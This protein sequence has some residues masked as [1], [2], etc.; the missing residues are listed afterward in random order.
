[1]IESSYALEERNAAQAMTT[2][3]EA[4]GGVPQAGF[5]TR[6]TRRRGAWRTAAGIAFVLSFGVVGLWHW[7][8]IWAGLERLQSADRRW[9]LLGA[10]GAVTAWLSSALAL[11]GAVVEPLATRRLVLSQI[12]A[13]AANQILPSGLGASAVSL[14]FLRLQGIS[15]P[16]AVA[17][18]TL[19]ASAG[20]VARGALIIGLGMAYPK[21]L[22]LPP[23]PSTWILLALVGILVLGILLVQTALRRSAQRIMENIKAVHMMSVRAVALWGGSVA[24]VLCQA[25]VL[26]TVALA[27][28]VHL[29]VAVVGLAAITASGAASLVP[30]PGGIGALDAALAAA[31]TLAGASV[32]DAATVVIGYR[33]LTVWLPIAPQLVLLA[34]LLRR[35]V[36]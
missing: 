5:R 16:D 33:L 19:K 30:T 17:A 10:L 8:S 25:S 32:G 36:V 11:Q 21:A 27:L 34:V 28:D 12:A 3:G 2:E 18:L 9:L 29:N 31:L 14:R 7:P 13:S 1:M 20:G 6:V 24:F 35:K 15:L 22:R 23:M 4:H 26:V